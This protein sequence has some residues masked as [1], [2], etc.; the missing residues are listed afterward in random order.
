M[1]KMFC[2]CVHLLQTVDKPQLNNAHRNIRTTKTITE[3]LKKLVVV[4]RCIKTRMVI[5]RMR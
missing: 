1:E 3:K 2:C 5:E 4:K